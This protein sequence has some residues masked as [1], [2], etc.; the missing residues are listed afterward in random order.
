MLLFL[1]LIACQTP[2]GADRHDLTGDRVAAVSVQP[3][4][5]VAGDVLVPRLALVT[6]GRAWSDELPPLLWSFVPEGDDDAAL[7]VEPGE[8]GSGAAPALELGED[9]RLV[10]SVQWPSG[11]RRHVVDI[12]ETGEPPELGAI[13]WAVIEDTRATELVGSD[14]SSEERRS[15]SSATASSVPTDGIARLTAATESPVRWMVTGGDLLELEANVT[16]W[17]PGSVT[18]NDFEIEEAEGGEQGFETVVAL[19]VGDSA[20]WRAV[21][22]PVGEDAPVLVTPSGRVLPVDAEVVSGRVQGIL[23]ADDSAPA[24]VRLEVLGP[25]DDSVDV[26]TADLCAVDHSGPFD[27]DWLLD[28]TCLRTEVVDATVVVEA[29]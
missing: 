21:D 26:G 16:D 3:S 10:L 22:V 14:V 15:W 8:A 1:A 17:F 29:R 13:D 6:D 2:F 20:V 18:V 19:A 7:S 5:G 9:R 27:P 28:G 4:G 11:E 24:G 23:R 12:P 25:V